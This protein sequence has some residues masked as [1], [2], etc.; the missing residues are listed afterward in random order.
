MRRR[1][2]VGW[3]EDEPV[4]IEILNSGKPAHGAGYPLP[5][6]SPLLSLSLTHW[7]LAVATLWSARRGLALVVK[8]GKLASQ[9]LPS[10]PTPWQGYMRQRYM[11][12]SAIFTP[13]ANP[14]AAKFLFRLFISKGTL[15]RGWERAGKGGEIAGGLYVP[16]GGVHAASLV[17]DHEQESKWD[18][19]FPFGYRSVYMHTMYAT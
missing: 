3:M 13:D 2:D 8:A 5:P 12:S 10:T 9:S 11:V 17:L 19:P 15:V 14:R 6:P 4:L 7:K 18:V 16:W 1:K